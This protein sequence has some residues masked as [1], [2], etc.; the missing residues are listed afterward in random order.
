MAVQRLRP[1][2]TLAQ[3]KAERNRRLTVCDWTQLPDSPLTAAVKKKWSEYRKALRDMDFDKMEWPASPD[4]PA[5]GVRARDEG[6]FVADDKSTP[7][8]N[9]AYEDG[10]TPKKKR[11]RKKKASS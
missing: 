2:E 6:K 7:N 1:V 3:K 4:A 10:K 5:S 11:A 9:E 8:V